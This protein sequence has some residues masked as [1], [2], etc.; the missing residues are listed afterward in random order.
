[1]AQGSRNML[2]CN[3]MMAS[4]RRHPYWEAVFAA[5]LNQIPKIK[6]S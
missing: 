2:V 6:A 3:A 5:L 1:M 4:K